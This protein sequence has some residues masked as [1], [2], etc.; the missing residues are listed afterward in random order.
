M[1]FIYIIDVYLSFASTLLA[2]C[3]GQNTYYWVCTNGECDLNSLIRPYIGH[4][5]NDAVGNM[6]SCF[7]RI[8][9]CF[10]LR[11]TLCKW[12]Q[13]HKWKW[14]FWPSIH[15]SIRLDK[16]L[17][18][19]STVVVIFF[20]DYFFFSELFGRWALFFSVIRCFD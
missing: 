2:L 8:Y 6:S 4:S 1:L 9:P 15:P 7:L 18:F 10:F 19:D 14:R 5:K 17:P 11:L 12:Y 13:S 16:L 20:F 3:K